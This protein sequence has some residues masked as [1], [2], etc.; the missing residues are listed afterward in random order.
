MEYPRPRWTQTFTSTMDLSGNPTTVVGPDDKLY[1]AVASKGLFAGTLT[2]QYT[3]FVGCLSSS[4]TTEWI[5]QDPLL[6]SNAEDVHP[7]LA[8]GT[9]GELYLAFTTTGNIPGLYNAADI[10][11]L[12][13]SC[14]STAGRQDL[15]VARINGVTV[16]SPSIAWRIQNGY[17]NSCNNEYLPTLLVA[18][19]RLLLVYQCNAATLCSPPVG[20]TNIICVS[21]D[22]NGNYHWTYQGNLLN[23]IGANQSPSIA[24]DLSGNIYIAY[25]ITSAVS[26]GTLLGTQDVEVVRLRRTGAIFVRDWILSALHT[27]NSP[28]INADPH[29]VFDSITTRLYLA[30]TATQAVPGGTK[31]ATGS[32]LVVV[33]LSLDGTIVF[34]KQTGAFN[35]ISYRY[36]SIDNPR[37]ALNQYGVVY[38]SAHAILEST[39]SEMI[40]AFQINPGTMKGWFFRQGSNE[41]NAYLAAADIVAPFQVLLVSAPFSRPIISTFAGQIYLTFV[42]YNSATLYVVALAQIINYLEYTSQEYMRNIVPLC[43]S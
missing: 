17:I 35:A 15:V 41:F 5:F 31:T 34:S 37:I 11:S 25:T 21:I 43:R 36:S 19:N 14:G 28:G 27:I 20:T 40:L 10:L 4:G 42:R 24:A 9:S 2:S 32:D 29:L 3:I 33:C 18:N 22:L 39:G 8:M 16:G 23:G 30:F 7:A 13:G 38:I 6:T 12:C 26:G 1:F